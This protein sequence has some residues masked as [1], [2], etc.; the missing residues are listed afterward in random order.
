VRYV[1]DTLS[2]TLA[3]LTLLGRAAVLAGATV[4]LAR[5]SGGSGTQAEFQG[6]LEG[7]KQAAAQY[8]ENPLVQALL[9]DETRLEVEQLAPQFRSDI[10]QRDFE[11][12]KF[13]AL[14]RCGEAVD[15]LTQKASFEQA[16]EVGQAVVQMCRHVAEKSQE[17]SL[18]GSSRAATDPME[19]AVIDQV[20]RVWG[21]PV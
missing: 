18:F 1:D 16:A 14:N 4:A 13:A 11:D 7:L 20:A 2:F 19:Q 15:L 10:K 6:I 17:G 5:Y 8:P 12:F 3:E 9:S 21:V